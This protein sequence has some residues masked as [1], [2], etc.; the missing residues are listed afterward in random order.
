MSFSLLATS[1]L[2]TLKNWDNQL[3]T[4][5]NGNLTNGFFDSL[6]PF[7]RNAINWAPLYL[8]VAAFAVIN[9]KKNGWWWVL[10][11]LATVAM[12]DMIGNYGFKH[13][14]QRLRPCNNPELGTT[15]RMMVD[16]C[17]GGFSFTSNHAAN[18]FGMATFFYFTARPFIKYAWL[19]FVW[20]GLVGYAQIYVGVH[21]PFD[22]LGGT[23]LGLI[24]GTF[25]G[26]LYHKRYG[27][28]IFDKQPM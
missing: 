8:F 25:T 1:L 2:E 27:I 14:F 13:N 17:S 23:A 15:I 10:F 28:S 16:Y 9:F 12:T 21:Y 11:L 26:K 18:H 5:I 24:I 20:A 19:G 3:F 22:V 7:M 4:L 6:M